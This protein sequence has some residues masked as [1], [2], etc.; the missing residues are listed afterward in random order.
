MFLE[1]RAASLSLPQDGC[2]NTS[3]PNLLDKIA[4]VSASDPGPEVDRDRT[5]WARLR[6]LVEEALQQP[7]SE[8]ESYLVRSGGDPVLIQ[9]ARALLMHEDD[10]ALE[11][12]SSGMLS[13]LESD[14]LAVDRAEDEEDAPKRLGPY[15][16]LR[17]LGAGGMGTVHLA[18]RDDGQFAKRVALKIVKRGMD[19]E[20]VLRRFEQERQVLA[21]LDHP[22]IA[23]VLDGGRC[24]D[25]RPYLVMELVEG[26]A[27]DRWCDRQAAGIRERVVLFCQVC[28]A[29]ADAHRSLVVHR[30]IKPSNVLVTPEG[31]PKLLDFGIAKVL[32]ARQGFRT[33][34]LTATPLKLLTPA[35]AS[36]EQIRGEPVTT[37]SDV[38]SL[39]VMLY[40]LL[41]GCTPLRFE[42]GS[43]S[44]I[45]RVVCT[46]EPERP[47]GIFGG[48][49]SSP[50][51]AVGKRDSAPG[52]TTHELAA[53]RGS[54][55]KAL[56]R[57]LAGDLDTIVLGALRKEPRRRYASAAELAADLRRYLEGLPVLVRPDTLGYRASRFVRRNR[58]PVAA[59]VLVLAS[60]V[61]GLAIATGQ[62]LRAE[63]AR[64][65]LAA[66]LAIDQERVRELEVQR[67]L[68]EDARA[69]ALGSL[70]AIRGLNEELERQRTLALERLED[71]RSFA[72]SLVF[73]V[74]RDLVSLEGAEEARRKIVTLGLE[75]LDRLARGAADDDP[76]ARALIGAYVRMADIQWEEERGGPE[77]KR[78]ALVS[79]ARA[80]EIGENLVA[81]APEHVP[82]RFAL[83]SALL[84]L[85][86]LL[87]SADRQEEAV[88]A[89]E[90][91]LGL[92]DPGAVQ[93][94]I[95]PGLDYLFSTALRHL[96]GV[97]RREGRLDQAESMLERSLAALE[98]LLARMPQ[99]RSSMA[100]LH[101]EAARLAAARGDA[102]LAVSELERGQLLL[103]E[104]LTV[105]P[106]HRSWRWLQTTQRIELGALLPRVGREREAERIAE[107]LRREL[108]ERLGR[109]RPS[110]TL[111]R[112]GLG[113]LDLNVRIAADA[114]RSTD[115]YA[116][117]RL[118]VAM[119]RELH[120]LDSTG[121]ATRVD[122]AIALLQQADLAL[123]LGRIEEAVAGAQEADRHLEVAEHTGSELPQTR[124]GLLAAQI[125]RARVE[126]RQAADAT[127]WPTR[128]AHLERA[129]EAWRA[130]K[131]LLAVHPAVDP[132]GAPDLARSRSVDRGVERC[133]EALAVSEL[134]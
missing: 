95:H 32:D 76:L 122:L 85:G 8:R 86:E 59:G 40:Q 92:V 34:D 44:E 58:A 20:E 120:D 114:G 90:R 31:R 77:A 45:E 41:T 30:D 103:R 118:R 129:L 119:A 6:A 108:E 91:T 96:A 7:A 57:A 124:Q 81:R 65:A 17:R 2:P 43:P 68:A 27:I 55:A 106:G 51:G 121:V 35:Y 37:A 39:G 4:T 10:C 12:P 84:T 56:R 98:P 89:F 82:N 71:G 75:A 78:E 80:I 109:D 93:E 38:Y 107:E 48:G 23:R 97:H 14:T 19:T 112:A 9:E 13:D 18:I 15:R 63:D 94:R 72:T 73:D 16:L 87:E 113:V 127:H 52:E 28:D 49:G 26:V 60:L 134:R 3:P 126:E 29:V 133:I 110:E 123:A 5:R 25:G 70:E 64:V 116:T 88:E 115:A 131:G 111:L 33:I 21:T 66:Q 61:G 105:D 69:Q 1:P 50:G 67:S 54:T 132:W 102:S 42:T 99:L 53:R 46:V 104:L 74:H 62:Y 117:A 130:A 125:L 36:P 11:P 83:G 101:S 47:S 79:L 24:P 100:A 22:G 128:Q